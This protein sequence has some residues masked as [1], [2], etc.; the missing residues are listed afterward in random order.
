[1]CNKEGKEWLGKEL[2]T[3]EEQSVEKHL[4]EGRYLTVIKVQRTGL[5]WRESLQ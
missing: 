4:M 5:G 2:W 3:K 1:M